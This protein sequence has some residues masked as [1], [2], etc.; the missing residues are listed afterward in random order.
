L[1][2]KIIEKICNANHA[3]HLTIKALEEISREYLDWKKQ[4]EVFEAI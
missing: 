4:E 3:E 1:S 2:P